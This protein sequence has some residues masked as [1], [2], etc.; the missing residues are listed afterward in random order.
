MIDKLN[1]FA[2][3]HIAKT[4]RRATDTAI[5]GIKYRREVIEKR[6]PQVTAWL[7]KRRK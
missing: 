4:S 3:A 6:L 7:A 2:D 1:A 5:A